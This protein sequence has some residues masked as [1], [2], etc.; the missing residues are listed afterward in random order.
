MAIG[1]STALPHSSAALELTQNNKGLLIPRVS[2]SGP[3]DGT[4]I[5]FDSPTGLL[6]YNTNAAMAGGGGTGFYYNANEGNP[7]IRNWVKIQTGAGSNTTWNL[8]GNSSI[9]STTNFLGTLDNQPLVFGVLGMIKPEQR[10]FYFTG[11]K[12]KLNATEQFC[13]A[14]G[15]RSIQLNNIGNNRIAI[16]AFTNNRSN[17]STFA[18]NHYN[19]AIG[20]SAI[21]DF[22]QSANALFIGS[23]AGGRAYEVTSSTGIGANVLYK[24][25]VSINTA[26]G[27]NSLQNLTGKEASIGVL[28]EGYRNTGFGAN[29]MGSGFALQDN[30]AIGFN[31]MGTVS[32]GMLHQFNVAI[33]SE[34]MKGLPNNK[35]ERNIAVGYQSMKERTGGENNVAVGNYALSAIG[36]SIDNIAIGYETLMNAS[37]NYNVAIGGGTAKNITTGLRNVAIGTA[38]LGGV[39]SGN[40]NTAIGFF[41]YPGGNYDNSI[42]IGY[43]RTIGASN[44]VRIGNSSVTSIGGQVAFT[45]L[46]DERAKSD[47]REDVQGISFIEKLAPVTYHIN[48]V[49][50]QTLEL[51]DAKIATV[52]PKPIPDESLHTGLEAQAVHQALLKSG[53]D[54]DIVDVPTHPNGIYGI[55][56]EL[57][58][59]PLVKTIQEQ[60]ATIKT[61]R[62]QLKELSDLLAIFEAMK[63]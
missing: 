18:A 46:S 36:Y 16:G 29:A 58:V 26:F 13:L 25:V 9:S 10:S 39:S 12:N 37:N 32:G 51:Q 60:Q 40:F 59:V 38:S 63:K 6:V 50:Q 8:T 55:R 17:Q 35:F 54:V 33:G 11:S 62:E 4:T 24:S 57:L 22:K 1:S 14:F 7:G 48:R 52:A 42:A 21:S 45:N 43:F 44:Q 15:D 34:A 47:I 61:I 30:T 41:A 27:A 5:P 20:D 49:E 31:T 28:L 53:M 3:N 2:L 19:V 56:Y 23:K